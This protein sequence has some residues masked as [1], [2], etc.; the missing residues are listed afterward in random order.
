MDRVINSS[1][2]GID[3]DGWEFSPVY[4]CLNENLLYNYFISNCT[5]DCPE[6]V[7]EV[8]GQCVRPSVDAG[9]RL[10]ATWKLEIMCTG[11]CVGSK[12]DATLHLMRFYVAEHLNITYQETVAV[13]LSGDL[14]SRRLSTDSGVQTIYLSITIVTDR[15][16]TELAVQ[17]MENYIPDADTASVLLGMEV[18]S[19]EQWDGDVAGDTIAQID[20]DSDPYS[21]EY[22]NLLPS[23][24][25]TESTASTE[26]DDSASQTL[27]LIIACVAGGVVVLVVAVAVVIWVRRSSK[28]GVACNKEED[29]SNVLDA[30][31]TE[32]KT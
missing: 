3:P 13:S 1:M 21:G 2:D 27:Y 4:Q 16:L 28:Q 12:V 18:T 23:K 29:N 10:T 6:G 17:L 32:E 24:S 9:T 26:S 15:V 20:T 22:V 14:T 8:S 11:D 19:V 7:V 31:K 5:E 25:E 30:A